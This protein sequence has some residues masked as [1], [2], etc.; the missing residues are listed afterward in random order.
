MKTL[1]I[2][3][4]SGYVGQMATEYAKKLGLNVIAAGRNAAK[5][6]KLAL[7][8][9]I[10]HR[11]F[12]LEDTANVDKELSDVTAIL[13]CA[14]P[15]YRTAE[16]LVRASIRTGTHYLDIAAELDSY[17]L[18]EKLDNEA[19]NAEI[20]LLPGSGGSVAMLGCLAGYAAKAVSKPRKVSIALHVSG[21]MSRG[22]AI[23]ASENMTSGVL[24][25]LN[26]QLVPQNPDNIQHFDFGKGSVPCFPVTLPD[27]ITIW[28]STQIP[29]IETFVHASGNAFPKGDLTA[30]PDGPN[31]EERDANRYQAAVNIIDDRGF[32]THAALDTVNGYTFTPIAAIEAAL[33]VLMLETKIY[34]GFHT[35]AAL[36]GHDFV[37]TIADTRIWLKHC[38]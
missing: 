26:G 11:I 24:Q 16:P 12:S 33:R 36:F 29:D 23:S 9:D 18:A 8:L 5:L 35:P 2:Y 30:L 1:M 21:S 17:L 15:Y 34:S 22:S 37:T 13:N 27:L 31:I 38:G 3:G 19:K 7:D 10:P 4:A 25:R 14:G 28:R 32:I 20:L 6:A